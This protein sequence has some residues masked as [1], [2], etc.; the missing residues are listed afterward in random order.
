MI[1][2]V[3]EKFDETVLRNQNRAVFGQRRRNAAA[4]DE[5]QLKSNRRLPSGRVQMVSFAPIWA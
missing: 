5:T 1:Q 2:F 3:M 4:A